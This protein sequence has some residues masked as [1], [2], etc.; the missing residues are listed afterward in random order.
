M[1]HEEHDPARPDL[2]PV[3]IAFCSNHPPVSH[4]RRY[5]ANCPSPAV[6]HRVLLIAALVVICLGDVTE[7]AAPRTEKEK[8]KAL[9]AARFFKYTGEQRT[10]PTVDTAAIRILPSTD[11]VSIYQSL[12][13]KPYEIIGV[14]EVARRD[15]SVRRALEAAQAGGADAIVVCPHEAFTAA[16]IKPPLELVIKGKDPR[17]V[18]SLVGLLIR[19][20]SDVAPVP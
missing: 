13:A 17:A 16:G 9:N 3:A 5:V 4:S 7:A 15:S 12:P 8:L 10:W 19:W 20:K 2:Q 11:R 1:R 14:I 6:Q 18:V